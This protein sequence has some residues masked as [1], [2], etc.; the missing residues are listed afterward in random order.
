MRSILLQK[1]CNI[2]L[3]GDGCHDI[4]H[5]GN[6]TRIS[7]EAPVPVFDFEYKSMNFG[8][9]LNVKE[10]LKSLGISDLD[11]HTYA[12]PIEHKNRY[13]DLKTKQQLFRV[14]HK[15]PM[16][17]PLN[18]VMTKVRLF[19]KEVG[20]VII[21]DYDKGTLS[22]ED[23]EEIIELAGKHNIPVFI[24]T[25]KKDYS[26]FTGAYVKINEKEY[27]ERTSRNDKMIVTRAD[28]S[29]IYYP[30]SSDSEYKEYDVQS[31]GFHDVTGAG[32]TF[33]AALAFMYVASSDMDMAIN[34]A[35][36]A[37]QISIQHYGC[38]APKL[39]EILE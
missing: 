30:T 31:L 7:P 26:R 32:D 20:C 27:N 10:N 36:K 5:Y 18:L 17:E 8:M 4:Y 19:I 33:L 13:L 21:S 24:D 38:Y 34:F 1:R 23:I 14:D 28:K 6:V 12:Y 22:V 3:I 16:N 2:M 25:K 9:A 37:S 35:I 29:V 39:E 11:I 15:V